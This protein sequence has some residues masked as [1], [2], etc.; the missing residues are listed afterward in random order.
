MP[1]TNFNT[2]CTIGGDLNVNVNK[3]KI[4]VFSKGA[5]QKKIFYYKGEIS[6]NVKEFKYPG[7]VLSRTGS[8][9]EAKKNLCSKSHVCSYKKNQIFE[10]TSKLSIPFVV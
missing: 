4:I 8:F 10:F 2:Y 7:I 1:S 9:T 3:T 5:I 6:E